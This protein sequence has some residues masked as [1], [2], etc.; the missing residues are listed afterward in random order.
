M[1]TRWT[2]RTKGNS[3]QSHAITDQD[4]KNVCCGISP[5]IGHAH[6]IVMAPEMLAAMKEF[7]R[8][9]EAGEI[10]SRKTYAQFKTII[11]KAEARP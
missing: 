6:L 4:G 5:K 1:N 9:C 3:V 11:A 8:R 7:V 10:M 2:I